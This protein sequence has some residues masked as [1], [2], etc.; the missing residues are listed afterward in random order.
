LALSYTTRM[1]L[2]GLAIGILAGLVVG[3]LGAYLGLPVGVRG[4]LTG[5]LV[6]VGLQ[7]MRK[8]M[9]QGQTPEA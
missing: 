2:T 4:G 1:I 7:Y 5:A 3:A 8:K 9:N 6:V